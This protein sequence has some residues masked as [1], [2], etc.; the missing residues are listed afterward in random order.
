VGSRWFHGGCWSAGRVSRHG[1]WVDG[2]ANVWCCS[3]C[4]S[5]TP[6]TLH[7]APLAHV[8][9]MPWLA[10]SGCLREKQWCYG[11]NWVVPLNRVAETMNCGMGRIKWEPLRMHFGFAFLRQILIHKFLFLPFCLCSSSQLELSVA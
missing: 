11:V 4:R 3:C 10:A 6:H 5:R 1:Q 9:L 2:I 8:F 7:S